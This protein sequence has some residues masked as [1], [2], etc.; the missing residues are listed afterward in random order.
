MAN[1]N[2]LTE[3]QIKKAKQAYNKYLW[4]IVT[5]C[6]TYTQRNVRFGETIIAPNRD[7]LLRRM[8]EYFEYIANV[9]DSLPE[10]I[11]RDILSTQIR[12]RAETL[13]H[14]ILK[15]E[16]S[17]YTAYLD[18]ENIFEKMIEKFP[19]AFPQTFNIMDAEGKVALDICSDALKKS[20]DKK[21]NIY[22]TIERYEDSYRDTYKAR[23]TNYLDNLKS[24][25]GKLEKLGG[26]KV[27][28]EYFDLIKE[29]K[30]SGKIEA[31]RDIIKL[32]VERIKGQE[33]EDG[34]IKPEDVLASYIINEI[35]L[36]NHRA[37]KMNSKAE[38]PIIGDSSV[39]RS[40]IAN[41]LKFLIQDGI[42][43]ELSLLIE[44]EKTRV[45][46]SGDEDDL[47]KMAITQVG[48]VSRL[49]VRERSELDDQLGEESI[50]ELDPTAKYSD[51]EG[52]KRHF[53]RL[54]GED[55]HTDL[56]DLCISPEFF[57]LL[58]EEIPGFERAQQRPIGPVNELKDVEADP[59][60]H[61]RVPI[62]RA[63]P[64]R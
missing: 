29:G 53:M 46:C 51:L 36:E 62:G 44:A 15:I 17:T 3:Q 26:K 21:D 31:K 10:Q 52:L 23:F 54:T 50:T 5:I 18:Y 32:L 4:Q 34:F 2:T 20:N 14:I 63:F 13:G 61:K 47:L 7:G 27:K 30:R 49:K 1:G 57:Q 39:L 45:V 28:K 64:H 58:C 24:T 8:G 41:T 35:N 11:Q 16:A 40:K 9:L 22:E 55:K 25:T 37:N 38:L 42:S 43:D 48:E 6:D 12:R 60:P 19:K 33:N 56:A 59:K